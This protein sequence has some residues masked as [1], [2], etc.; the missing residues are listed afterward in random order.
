MAN[1]CEFEMK[2]EGT[3]QSIEKA[4]EEMLGKQNS[5]IFPRTDILSTKKTTKQEREGGFFSMFQ[6]SGQCDWS[7]AVSML[8]STKYQNEKQ[9]EYAT[10][11]DFAKKHN[12]D[13]EIYG[14]D[15]VNI[16]HYQVVAG[17]LRLQENISTKDWVYLQKGE[18]ITSSIK[19][20][21]KL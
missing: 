5:K 4:Y 7:L 10:I 20:L 3:D 13:I 21:S 8:D 16:E 17:E 9:Y 14:S 11:L 18:E 6:V 2:I 1:V 12:L 19:K 15:G